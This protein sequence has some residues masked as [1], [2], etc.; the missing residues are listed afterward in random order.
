MVRVRLVHPYSGRLGS[1]W[2]PKPG[3]EVEVTA[4]NAEL[5]VRK[6]NTAEFV[7]QPTDSVSTPEEPEAEDAPATPKPK[8]VK[9]RKR[10]T[11]SVEER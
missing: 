7:E 3:E 10:R 1:V 4:E 9:R 5:L 2:N 8:P 6:W 11:S